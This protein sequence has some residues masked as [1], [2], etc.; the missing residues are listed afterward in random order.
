MSFPVVYCL[1]LTKLFT[2]VVFLLFSLCFFTSY[3]DLNDDDMLKFLEEY[4]ITATNGKESSIEI[5]K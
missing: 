4:C 1:L 3:A 5:G 2:I